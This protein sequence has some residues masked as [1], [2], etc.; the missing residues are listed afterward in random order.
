MRPASIIALMA[1]V[2]L[3]IIGV[4]LMRRRVPPN[5]LYGLRL[6]GTMSDERIWYEVNSRGGRDILVVAAVLAAAAIL[7]PTIRLPEPLD[8]FG[9]L[10]VLGVG[11]TITVA[12]ASRHA[13]RLRRNP[14][15]GARPECPSPA[16]QV[17]QQGNA[18]AGAARVERVLAL[19]VLVLL[20]AMLWAGSLYAWASMPARH[21]IH[22]DRAGT[23]DR[24][25]A[26]SLLS[27]LSI[28]LLATA[29]ALAAWA[30]GNWLRAKIARGE[31]TRAR[32]PGEADA[33][34]KRRAALLVQ[35]FLLWTFVVFAGML[36]VTQLS[37]WHAATGAVG[38]P[39]LARVSPAFLPSALGF[40]TVVYVLRLVRLASGERA[41]SSAPSREG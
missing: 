36:S 10:L 13:E 38:K 20:L 16:L 9:I 21:P 14:A 3:F 11:G 31:G 29:G 25:V 37:V 6:P 8:V 1:A 23:P 15:G 24:W 39:P 4:P 34:T 12:R 30:G 32:T 19:S 7:T 26:T 35:N 22:F 27:W 18:D 2:T 28:P 5:P 40:L 33:R 17:Q 41:N